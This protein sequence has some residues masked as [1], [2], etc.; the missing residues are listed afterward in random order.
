MGLRLSIV[1]GTLVARSARAFMRPVARPITTKR[2]D[3]AGEARSVCQG[4]TEDRLESLGYALP[5][6]STP[7]GSYAMYSRA[8]DML[9]LAGHIPV[10]PDG[11]ICTGVVGKDINKAKG[12]DAARL[13]GLALLRT[14]SDAVGLDNVK[15]VHNCVEIN[16]C[17]GCTRQFFTKSFLGDDEAVVVPSS[18]DEPASPRHRAGV[19]S[20]AWRTTRRFRTNA[21]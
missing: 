6:A 18:S 14:L 7:K 19:A 5:P 8:G 3:W 9:F 12:T 17:V 20:M 16:Q 1:G 21:P 4:A 11:S 10:R 2:T 13:C 15:Q